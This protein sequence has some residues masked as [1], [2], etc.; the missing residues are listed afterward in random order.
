MPFGTG[1]KM[2]ISPHIIP[3]L[4]VKPLRSI[5]PSK[6]FSL[7]LCPFQEVLSSSIAALL[8]SSP[9]GR[10][11]SIIHRILELSSKGL[12]LDRKALIEQWELE[13]ELE[14]QKMNDSWLD[15]HFIPL[16]LN[17]RDFDL[18]RLQC[19]RM[20]SSLIRQHNVNRRYW[21]HLESEVRVESKDKK[22]SGRID[23]IRSSIG[24]Q[25]QVVDYKAIKFENLFLDDGSLKPVYQLQM[26]LYC[27]LFYETFNKWPDRLTIIDLN[28]TEYD[29][30]FTR[31]ECLR[32][33]FEATLDFDS[34]NHSL[35]EKGIRTLANPT[36]ST[37]FFCKYRPA[38]TS[39]LRLR[40]PTKEWPTDFLGTV[41]DKLL[42]GNGKYKVCATNGHRS[43]EIRGLDPNRHRFLP[44]TVDGVMFFNLH[45]DLN[46]NY[47]IETPYT[48]VYLI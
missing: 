31:E 30:P 21:G 46:E 16:H 22:V 41:T 32:L 17:V 19:F 37:C 26:K 10:V 20:V 1:E 44:G 9:V 11:N 14:H 18:K 47:Y 34:I 25:I 3:A 40:R 48:T 12:I 29:V 45:Q 23:A 13:I 36:P 42:L 6:Y 38:C 15:F 2:P 43:V 33:L 39:Y 28:R 4:E 8:P 35:Q 5:S 24:G 7:K 27:A